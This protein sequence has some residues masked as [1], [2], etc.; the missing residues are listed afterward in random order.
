V[1]FAPFV[2]SFELAFCTAMILLFLATPLAWWLATTSSRSKPVVEAIAALPIVLPPSVLGYYMLVFMGHDGPLASYLG[3]ELLF[4]FEGLLVASV[5]YSFPFMLQPLQGAFEQ[6]SDSMIY[7]ARLA[8]KGLVSIVW[9][10]ALPAI[11]KTLLGA[12]VISFAHT[13]GEFGVVLMVG[14]AVEGET[15]VASVA[16]YELVEMMRYD[17]ANRYALVMLLGSLGVLVV[18]YAWIKKEPHGLGL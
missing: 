8:G 12:W 15:K 1:S 14:G 2:L 10:V 3:I 17:E 13:V 7:S 9:N 6:L 5:L 16:L 11:K 4:S 18:M